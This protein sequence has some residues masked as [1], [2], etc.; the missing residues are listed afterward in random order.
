MSK[1]NVTISMSQR[2]IERLR[3]LAAC[4]GYSVSDF[5]AQQIE[6][7]QIEVLIST[8]EAAE[9]AYEWTQGQ[10]MQLLDQG[11]H[12]GNTIRPCRDE[13]HER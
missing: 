12:L 5:L 2:S 8:E 4:N 9:A 13:L 3:V 1:L 7:Q 6:V 11:F 10:A